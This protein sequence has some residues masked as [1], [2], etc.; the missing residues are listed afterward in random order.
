M[1][2]YELGRIDNAVMSMDD[3]NKFQEMLRDIL[4]IARVH[5]NRLEVNEIKKMFGDMSLTETQYE[6]IFAYLAANHINIK[7]YIA[8]ESEYTKVLEQTNA[9]E[10]NEQSKEDKSTENN[11][12]DEDS[13][14]LEMYLK[15]IEDIKKI[16]P[17]E[18]TILLGKIIKGD[19]IAKNRYI[20]GNLHYVVE[21]AKEYRNQ[22]VSLEDLI[23]EG[24][25]GLISSLE[26]VSQ[27]SDTNQV[28]D[29]VTDYIK[30]FME[31]AIQKKKENTNFE[32]SLVD[33][34]NRIR[35]AAEKLAEELG[36][37]AN[38]HELAEYIKMPEKEIDDVINMATEGIKI[39][40]KHSSK[41]SPA[42]KSV[43][44]G[45]NHENYQ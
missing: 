22:G 4:E 11:V 40:K 2:I 16:T 9:E 20:E 13:S 23:Q 8:K 31:T 30:K 19:D 24:N 32:K 7:G 21:L 18:E 45:N 29:R 37:K 36:R 39:E 1:Q 44:Y 28:K 43:T 12:Q 25:M 17:D 41:S 14:Y 26:T 35:D 34:I 3:K 27:L 15:D 33:K 42:I 6:Q 38:I 10:K 5:G